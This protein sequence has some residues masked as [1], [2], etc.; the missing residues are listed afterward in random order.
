M[1]FWRV[2]TR[3][4][5]YQFSIYWY[6]YSHNVFASGCAF[7]YYFMI[8]NILVWFYTKEIF[9]SAV[10]R[11]KKPSLNLIGKEGLSGHFMF[12]NFLSQI[13]CQTKNI[14]QIHWTGNFSNYHFTQWIPFHKINLSFDDSETRKNGY[15]TDQS[16][17]L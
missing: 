9:L 12:L 15:K 17:A 3:Y 8:T 6:F 16:A 1:S 5:F 13:C 2:K 11:R 14:Q 4:Q 10:V 7:C